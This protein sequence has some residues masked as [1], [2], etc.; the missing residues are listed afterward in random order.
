MN[1]TQGRIIFNCPSCEQKLGLEAPRFTITVGSQGATASPEWSCPCGVKGRVFRGK[2]VVNGRISI[3]P[4]GA[5]AAG[6]DLSLR[7]AIV[8]KT[9]P[10]PEPEPEPLPEEAPEPEA[11]E[12][13]EVEGEGDSQEDGPCPLRRSHGAYAAQG[14]RCPGCGRE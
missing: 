2:V 10:E 3:P 14:I 13:P 5:I 6:T 11:E 12:D 9:Q 4:S 7:E 8:I 1:F